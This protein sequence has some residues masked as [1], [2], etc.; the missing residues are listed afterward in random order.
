M[1]Q[2]EIKS[3]RDLNEL[4]TAPVLKKEQKEKLLK[5]LHMEMAKAEW[6]TLGIM[7][8]SA[9]QSLMIIRQIERSLVW[10]PME[11]VEAPEE[12]GP[13]FLKAN[14][15]SGEIRIRHE[16]GLGEGIL[17]SSHHTDPTEPTFT[18]GP[19]PLALFNS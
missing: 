7:A 8:P 6:F 15:S 11:L 10:P 17:I 4:R 5:E 3:L 14:Q 13:V 19:L 12:E 1:S 18:W 16:E 2:H 9:N